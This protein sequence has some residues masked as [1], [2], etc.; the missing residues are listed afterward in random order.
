MVAITA[1]IMMRLKIDLASILIVSA[2]F[3][4]MLCL[5][6]Y[7]LLKATQTTAISAAIWTSAVVI[8]AVVRMRRQGAK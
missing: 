3:I 1:R 4:S 8:K 2:G 6:G 7:P 5:L